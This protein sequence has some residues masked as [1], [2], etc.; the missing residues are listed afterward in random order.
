MSQ[1]MPTVFVV[2]PNA[3]VRA[4]LEPLLR[5]SGWKAQTFG[6]AGE[7][8]ACPRSPAPSCLVIEVVLPDHEPFELLRRIAADRRE[9][10]I[11]GMSGVGD[12][13]MTVRAMKAGAV[14]F[15]TK[16]L[17]DDALLA[18]VAHALARSRRV[19]DQEAEL[20]ELRERHDSLSSREREV[21]AWVVAGLLNKQV[22]AS[23]GIS[24]ITVKA[25]RGR[26]M[27]KMGA[28]SLAQLVSMA[29]RLRLTPER[30]IRPRTFSS[31]M[32]GITLEA[33][34]TSF[35]G[36]EVSALIGV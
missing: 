14:E 25:H 18:A 4:A 6:S 13:P 7:F 16:P 21:M 15:L 29:V 24:E 19:L 32:R 28:D 8:L 9:T 31:P 30:A 20:R 35:A 11:I 22:G 23:L 2:D 27:R 36:M 12:I 17:V 26:V 1:F 33:G 10:P 5:R 3:S 34:R